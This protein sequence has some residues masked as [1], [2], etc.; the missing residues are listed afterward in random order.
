M[1]PGVCTV[2]VQQGLNI[3]VRWDTPQ[4]AKRASSLYAGFV[5]RNSTQ[6][7]GVARGC[8]LMGK[9]KHHEDLPAA[10]QSGISS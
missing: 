1:G 6:W 5:Q 3:I 4:L 7:L 8:I 2:I 10:I 9:G